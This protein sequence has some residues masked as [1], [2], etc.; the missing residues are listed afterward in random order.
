MEV[1]SEREG[2]RRKKRRAIE[3]VVVVVVMG[4]G[5]LKR[6]DCVLGCLFVC[7]CFLVSSGVSLIIRALLLSIA[8]VV[9]AVVVVSSISS[10]ITTT[11]VVG[12]MYVVEPVRE[13]HC[14]IVCSI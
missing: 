11:L 4:F 13:G 1:A 6:R 5:I 8:V 12:R 7:M 2:R 9:L 3:A 10:Y 14:G